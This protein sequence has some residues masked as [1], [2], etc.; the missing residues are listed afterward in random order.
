MNGIIGMTQLTLDT[1]LTAEQRDFLLM[2]KG[3]A[4]S[5]LTVLNDILDFSKIEARQLSLEPIAFSPSDHVAELVRPLALKAREKQLEVICEVCPDVPMEVIGDPGRLRQVLLNLVG[6]AIKFTHRGQILVQVYVESREPDTVTLHYS[7]TDT[8][9]GVPEDKHEAI[10]HAFQQGDGSTTRRFGGT[11]LGLAISSTLV[12]MM[13]GRLWVESVLHEGSVFH[14]TAR[15]ECPILVTSVGDDRLWD[16]VPPPATMGAESPSHSISVLLVEDNVVN[17]R[18]AA[19]LLQRYGHRVTTV[20][21]GNEAL[22]A[23]EQAPFDAV[24]MDVQMPEMNGLEA[25]RAIRVR[26]QR[27]GGHVPIVAMTAHAMKG[28][29]K[30]CLDAGMDEYLTKPID[31]RQLYAVLERLASRSP[32]TVQAS[33]PAAGSVYDAVLARVGGDRELLSEISLLFTEDMPCHLASIQQSIE[34][35]D[36]EA[37]QR[38]AHLLRGAAANFEAPALVQTAR[39]LEEMGRTAQFT[40]SDSAWRTLVTEAS[41]LACVLESYVLTPLPPRPPT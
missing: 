2:V 28:D 17:Q 35:R 36:G 1:D 25:T 41:V 30:R 38:A 24:L 34:A 22:V 15:F 5:L 39:T 18:L 29:R 27:T 16:S 21:N 40:E 6:N 13:G 31:P 4:D 8:G 14:F 12:Q 26:E 10:F 7:V 20:N 37:L 3:S 23:V 33:E 11:G 9:I 32:R 19:S